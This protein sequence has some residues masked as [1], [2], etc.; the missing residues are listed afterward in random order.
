MVYGSS[1][2][3]WLLASALDVRD[4]RDAL[5]GATHRSGVLAPYSQPIIVSTDVG[6]SCKLT[7]SAA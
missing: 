2:S 3:R 7:G 1:S 6:A 4:V 5:G